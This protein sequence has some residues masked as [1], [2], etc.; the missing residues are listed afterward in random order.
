M[1]VNMSK[2][3]VSQQISKNSVVKALYKVVC[4]TLAFM[5][6][7]IAAATFA[8]QEAGRQRIEE[9]VAE[10][11]VATVKQQERLIAQEVYLYQQRAVYVRLTNM[12]ERIAAKIAVTQLCL[13]LSTNHAVDF[14]SEPIEVCRS[15]PANHYSTRWHEVGKIGLGGELKAEIMFRVTPAYSWKTSI[16]REVLLILACSTLLAFASGSVLI[17]RIKNRIL[18][19]LLIEIETQSRLAAIASMTQMVAHDVR[20]P[21][22]LLRIGL[23]QIR[24]ATTIEKMHEICSRL[25]LEI[26]RAVT[27]TNNLLGDILDVGATVAPFRVPVEVKAL[28]DE[29]VDELQVLNPGSLMEI[30]TV[31]DSGP[32]VSVDAGKISR[33][34]SNIMTN[35]VQA[36]KGAGRITIETRDVKQSGENLIEFSIHN[37][38]P[39]IKKEHLS[40]VF[41][42]FFTS[43][44]ANGTGLGLAIAKKHVEAHGGTIQCQSDGLKGVSFVFTLPASN[45]AISG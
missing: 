31:Y 17:N 2:T 10:D 26:E 39:P 12:V 40:Q 6:L 14:Y 15:N 3:G 18:T 4:I 43:G 7:G 44:K 8:I 37:D 32:V 38:G 9:A 13:R 29:A 42:T 16:P 11:L 24:S 36:M 45:Q 25:A 21:F 1:W 28:V 22:S 27:K 34:F 41:E 33:V 23:K 30:K 19:P 35:A 5:I 20:R